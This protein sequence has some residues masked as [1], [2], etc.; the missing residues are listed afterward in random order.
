MW[1]M[2][3]CRSSRKIQSPS[4]SK[5]R[6]KVVR[7]SLSDARSG[8]LGL[9][10]DESS[11]AENSDVPLPNDETREIARRLRRT[12]LSGV[13]TGRRAALREEARSRTTQPSQDHMRNAEA[14]EADG[15]SGGNLGT[16]RGVAEGEEGL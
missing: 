10:S 11:I 6:L 5:A 16:E 1:R 2:S 13:A 15:V 8:P 12:F 9:D 14:F 3:H 7:G 4:T